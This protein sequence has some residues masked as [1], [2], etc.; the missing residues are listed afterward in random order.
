MRDLWWYSIA[1]ITENALI[2]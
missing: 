1:E 2:S